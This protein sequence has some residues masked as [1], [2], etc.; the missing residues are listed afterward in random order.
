MLPELALT[1]RTAPDAFMPLLAAGR[2]PGWIVETARPGD[3]LRTFAV[4]LD[5][6]SQLRPDL[7]G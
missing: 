1:S 5:G 7:P 6:E 4:E 3:I 2:L